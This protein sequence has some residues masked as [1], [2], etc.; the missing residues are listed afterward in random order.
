MLEG[1]P[2]L[3]G[4]ARRVR[5]KGFLRWK[6][7]SSRVPARGSSAERDSSRGSTRGSGKYRITRAVLPLVVVCTATSHAAL[8]VCATS[9]RVGMLSRCTH[10]P[11]SCG[12]VALCGPHVRPKGIGCAACPIRTCRAVLRGYSCRVLVVCLRACTLYLACCFGRTTP[13]PGWWWGGFAS[14][15]GGGG[16]VPVAHFTV[17]QAAH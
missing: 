4:S 17:M 7:R 1:V 11:T 14:G 2:T 5:W 8:G 16:V 3:E 10:M 13:H 15:W 6:E 9:A 12:P